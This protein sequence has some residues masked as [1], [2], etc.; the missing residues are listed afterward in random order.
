MEEGT[1]RG[2]RERGA[3]L[4]SEN[5]DMKEETLPDVLCLD[6][7]RRHSRDS[8]LILGAFFSLS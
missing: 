6:S 5:H 3:V 7:V 2:P 4:E 8:V 1:W